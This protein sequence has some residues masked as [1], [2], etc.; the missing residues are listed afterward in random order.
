MSLQSWQET[1][2]TNVAVGPTITATTIS[3]ILPPDCVY[4]LPANFFSVGKKLR[5]TAIG[6]TTTTVT[7]PGTKLFTVNLGAVAVFV[8]PAMSLNIVAG[9]YSWHLELLMN[10]TAIGSG[11]LATMKTL[12][13]FTSNA[14]IGS[15]APAAGGVTTMMLPNTAPVNGAGFSSVISQALDL[16]VTNSVNDGEILHGYKVE[17]LN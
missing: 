14:I 17:A 7:T 2:I 13:M 9:T 6:Q 3:S 5:I 1:L 11:T 8:T 16:L 10:C 4:T 15:A 12:G